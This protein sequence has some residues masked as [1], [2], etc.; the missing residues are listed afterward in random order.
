MYIH[1]IYIYILYQVNNIVENIKKDMRK[2]DVKTHVR[3]EFQ[4]IS[5]N[6]TYAL[7]RFEKS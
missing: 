1:I 2:S 7:S 4:S 3:Q 5:S 6:I